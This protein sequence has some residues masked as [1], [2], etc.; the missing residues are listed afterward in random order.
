MRGCRGVG[1]VFVAL[2]AFVATT[3][4]AAPAGAA[5]LNRPADPVVLTG[6]QLTKLVGVPPAQIIGFA[7]TTTGWR[8]IPIQVD[9]RAMLN[10]GAVYNG[11][12]PTNVSVLGYTS[13][14]TWA[15]KDPNKK[16]DADDELVF[17]A[18]DTGILATTSTPPVGTK[19]GTGV[20]VRVTDPLAPGNEGYA[21]LFRK[22]P[23]GGALKPGAGQ[24]Y[25]Q[26]KFKVL[27]GSYKNKYKFADGPNPE[28]SL[29]TAPYYQHHFSDR[30]ASDR[31]NV[32]VG[33]SSRVDILD[34]H[35]NLFAP[36]V[37][38]RSEDTFNDGEGAFITNTAGPVRAIRSYVGANSGPNT[39]RDHFFYDRR[40]DIRTSLRVHAIPGMMDFFDYSPAASGM[41]YRNSL[42]PTGF[43]IDGVPDSP[44]AGAPTWEQVTG[45]QGSLTMIPTIQTTGFTPTGVTNYYL[46]DST[47]P[48]TQCTGDSA[49]YG[50]SGVW[51]NGSIPCLDP[52]TA[53]TA[54]L[55]GTRT[56]YFGAPGATAA[57]ATSLSNG[58]AQPLAA[59]GTSWP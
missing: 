3:I 21:Y 49:A 47:P 8:Q 36:G 53:C 17:M 18:R 5:P 29:V 11:A 15:G 28:D 24:Q 2:A 7:A 34:R 22:G 41:T 54:T 16:F 46:D 23:G 1:A 56:M 27:G 42:N 10:L 19:A 4:T 58:V 31:L 30:W 51:I 52:G 55:T 26:Y 33:S 57:T 32:T 37:C 39:Q 38:G 44:V 12:Y 59:T 50:S 6:A 40:E 43:A 35:K 48:Q 14:K 20:R 25:V 9:E 45:P 13:N